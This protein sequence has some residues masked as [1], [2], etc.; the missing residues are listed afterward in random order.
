MSKRDKIYKE[1][2]PVLVKNFTKAYIKE[3]VSN[4]KKSSL[5]DIV[6]PISIIAKYATSIDD[7]NIVETCRLLELSENEWLE[8]IRF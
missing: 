7:K 8:E 2:K 4:I 1:I 6:N 3:A 5:N